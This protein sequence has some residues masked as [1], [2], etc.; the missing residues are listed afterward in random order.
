MY[1]DSIFQ[2]AFITAASTA[3][4]AVGV[5]EMMYF[6]FAPRSIA[7][8]G[9]MVELSENMVNITIKDA[10]NLAFESLIMWTPKVGHT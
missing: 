9:T 4:L 3:A 1:L 8:D 2:P 10:R 5:T 7:V 6:A